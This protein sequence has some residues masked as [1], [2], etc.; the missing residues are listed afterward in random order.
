MV[1]STCVDFRA[2]N[3]ITVKNHY[4]L[5]QIDDLLDQLKDVVYFTKLGLRIGYH[6][7]RIAEGDIWKTNFKRKKGLFEWLVMPFGLCNALATF[8]RVMNDVLMPFLDDF[9]IVYLDDILVF[10]KSCEEHV[11]HVKQVLD[12][13]KKEKLF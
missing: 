8:M 2:L 10:N 6:Q 13:L 1:H 11:R 4:P 5:P 3:K 7:I 12:V 9:V